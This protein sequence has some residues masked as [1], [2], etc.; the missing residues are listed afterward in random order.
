MKYLAE[1][2][3]HFLRS[4]QI[5]DS[6]ENF[7]HLFDEERNK[8]VQEEVNKAQEK[9]KNKS[10]AFIDVI[11]DVWNLYKIECPICRSEA[12]LEGYTDIDCKG[13]NIDD[14]EVWLNFY[15]DSF[16]CS[17]CG[18]EL[19]GVEELELVGIE[20]IHDRTE[21]IDAWLDELKEEYEA[22]HL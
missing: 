9:A 2:D 17:E 5:S 21:D 4:F 16:E 10:P 22:D 15:G 6:D 8:R 14:A 7:Y 19:S 11:D 18:L 20:P 1:E 3:Y 12:F 13:T